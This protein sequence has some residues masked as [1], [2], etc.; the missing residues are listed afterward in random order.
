MS[1]FWQDVVLMW[2][3]VLGMLGLCALSQRHSKK[4]Q[5]SGQHAY[6]KTCGAPVSEHSEQGDAND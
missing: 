1:H 5:R 4:D 3:I 6:C 2:S